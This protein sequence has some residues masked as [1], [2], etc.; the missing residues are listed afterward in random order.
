MELIII[1]IAV[2]VVLVAFRYGYSKAKKR[3]VSPASQYATDVA[4]K[5]DEYGY[6]LT[7]HGY[8]TINNYQ[9]GARITGEL[10]TPDELASM[11][12]LHSM[13]LDALDLANKNDLQGSLKLFNHGIAAAKLLKEKHD[14]GKVNAEH[15]KEMATL[16]A[17]IGN[18]NS[19]QMDLIQNIIG[20]DS[21]RQA[22]CRIKYS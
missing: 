18:I 11:I 3:F 17:S 15:F 5:I 7:L 12:A 14:I 20:A 8:S 22:I 2:F 19:T 13:A 10:M 9:V 6:T 21:E 1:I 4:Y 16:F